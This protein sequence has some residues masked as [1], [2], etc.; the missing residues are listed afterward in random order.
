MFNEKSQYKIMFGLIKII[1]FR[2]LIGL[3]NQSNHTKCV[4]LTNQ[5]CGTEPTIINLH[6]NKYTQGLHYDP[7]VITLDRCVRGCNQQTF[8]G[9]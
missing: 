4:S 5:K 1:F 2:L 9:L 6:L 7:F 3:V 8:V